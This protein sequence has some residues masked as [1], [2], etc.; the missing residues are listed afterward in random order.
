MPLNTEIKYLNDTQILDFFR[1][2]T[3]RMPET[4][5]VSYR[6]AVACMT[7]F[8]MSYSELTDVSSA[9]FLENWVV[10]MFWRGLTAKTALHYLEM[11]SALCTSV[12][13]DG[14]MDAKAQESFRQVK[15]RF[16]QHLPP[17]AWRCSLSDED[18]ARF[19]A[20]TQ[21][22]GRRVENDALFVDIL[23]FSLINKGMNITDVANLRS[24]DLSCYDEHSRGIAQ[25][26]TDSHR[27][28]VF[29]LQQ[30]DR[31]A[32]QLD[33]YVRV[34]LE[35][36]LSARRIRLSGCLENTLK[37][38]WAYAALKSGVCG[39]DVVKALGSAPDG[40]PVL[41]L[42]EGASLPENNGTSVDPAH[43][44]A[45]LFL[46]DSVGWYAMRLRNGVQFEKL[47]AR[48]AGLPAKV[49]VPE[50][51]YPMEAIRHRV[52]KRTIRKEVPV[53]PHIVFFKSRLSEI[54][55][56]FAWIGDIAWCYKTGNAYS[57]IPSWEMERFQQA[58]GS[59][60]ADTEILPAGTIPLRKNDR[61]EILGG[62]FAGHS[63]TIDT[64][65]KNSPLSGAGRLIYRLVL[66]ADNGVEWVVNLD[67][68][69]IKS[70]QDI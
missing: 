68:R 39:S 29:P 69:L 27:R 11:I 42:C 63:A 36:M 46:A 5:A 70:T 17:D 2:E 60:T 25:K 34:K 57:R 21:R 4:T 54:Q 33:K 40:L 14:W 16:K 52:G 61:V 58:I 66:P 28:Y 22:A 12:V 23:L 51:F 24:D 31:T 20:F 43:I 62:M 38:Y 3:E 50:L 47:S 53:L 30:S 37:T 56:L 48:L 6:K 59:F 13:K 45:N 7:D 32:R 18:F 19:A 35:Q 65:I 44:V 10:Y 67:S 26:Y 64:A 9:F 1:S 49:R 15:A 41:T 55:S 8:V